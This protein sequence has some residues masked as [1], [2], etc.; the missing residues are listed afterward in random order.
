MSRCFGSSSKLSAK[1]YTNKKSN[2]NLVCDLREKFVAKGYKSTGTNN[3]CINSS[4][5]ITKFNSQND[6]LKI[7]RGYEQFLSIH[8]EDLSQNYIGQQIKNHFCNSYPIYENNIDVSNNYTPRTTILTLAESGDTGQT[9]IV[10]SSGTYV[11][12]YAEISNG[13]APTGT[14]SFPNKKLIIYQSCGTSL[15]IRA[16]QRIQ[17]II[18][19][20]LPPPTILLNGIQFIIV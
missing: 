6:Q 20:E 8:R 2:Y 11:N 18:A 15:P 10:D 9:V 14:N 19:S 7:K 12:R 17:I 5:F 13:T 3:A 1:D 4:G 16:S